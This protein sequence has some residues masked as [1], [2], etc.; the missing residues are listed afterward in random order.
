MTNMMIGDLAQKTST[1]ANTV[2]YYEDIGLLPEPART[3]SGRRTYAESDVRRLSFVRHSRGFGF[4]IDEI[5]SLLEISDSPKQDCEAAA[6]IAQEHLEKID[7]QIVQLTSLRD[8]LKLFATSCSGGSAEH[9]EIIGALNR[10]NPP[11]G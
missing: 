3:A 1:K 6:K 7:T 4:S 10:L 9:C 2:R 5:R 11:V 8:A